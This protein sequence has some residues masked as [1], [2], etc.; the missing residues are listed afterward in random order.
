MLTLKPPVMRVSK[1]FPEMKFVPST[2]TSI[3]DNMWK[4]DDNY[5]IQQCGNRYE[6]VRVF[7]DA[8]GQ[9]LIQFYGLN[10]RDPELVLLFAENIKKMYINT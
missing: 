2:D 3:E 1:I 5:S 8:K 6:L 4:L 10:E 9:P 7:H